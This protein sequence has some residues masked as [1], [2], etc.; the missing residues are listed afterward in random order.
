MS[1]QPSFVVHCLG[2]ESR[3]DGYA[4][5]YGCSSV[6]HRLGR[7]VDF[8]IH[9]SHGEDW[10]VSHGTGGRELRCR[11]SPDSRRAN[12]EVGTSAVHLRYCPSRHRIRRS[13]D[14][15]L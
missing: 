11:L 1:R 8:Q 9:D 7:A 12:R 3:K 6:D 4:I 5:S 14:P 10:Y 2:F 13:F 15:R